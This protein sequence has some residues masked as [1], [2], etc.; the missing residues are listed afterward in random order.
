MFE[1]CLILTVRNQNGADKVVLF[2]LLFTWNMLA[3][4]SPVSRTDQVNTAGKYSWERYGPNGRSKI[5]VHNLPIL[6]DFNRKVEVRIWLHKV[7][8]K[9]EDERVIVQIAV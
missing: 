5:I 9:C 7:G 2:S 4:G 3:G 8:E 6:L 1:T